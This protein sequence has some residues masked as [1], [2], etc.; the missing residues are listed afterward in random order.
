MWLCF[1]EAVQ[2]LVAT[3]L[4]FLGFL[5]TGSKH[6]TFDFVEVDGEAHLAS[7]SRPAPIF[8]LVIEQWAIGVIAMTFFGL[9]IVK[10]V[11]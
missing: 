5:N 1:V 3:A 2:I 6:L 10:T 7:A 9:F 8:S 11:S 4:C